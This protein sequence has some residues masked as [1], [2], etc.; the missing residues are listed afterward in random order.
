MA[1]AS[2][3]GAGVLTW[4][5]ARAQEQVPEPGGWL[6]AAERRHAGEMRY[7]R[8][9][10]DFLASRWALKLAVARVLGW[11]DDDA[12]LARISA[13]TAAD[14]APELLVDGRPGGRGISLSHR[15][16]RAACLVAGQPAAIGCDLE[17]VEPRTDAFVRDYLTEPER[18]VVAAAGPARDV[19]AN[20][21]WSAK[22]SAL[23]VLRTGLRRD[24]RS[25]EVTVADLTP[26]QHAW[27]PLQVRAVE[28]AV[29]HGWWRHSG[30]F[31]LTACAPSAF[32]PPTALDPAALDPATVTLH[33]L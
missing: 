22:E 9:R 31:I 17:F 24:T 29:F 10:A 14:G 21:I 11:P 4:W 8:R 13:A 18:A 3:A 26:P 1:K 19:A 33:A 32:P 27:S 16:G 28:G 6:T 23:K 15:A 20:L 7:P 30:R 5:L 2:A 25:V 12:A